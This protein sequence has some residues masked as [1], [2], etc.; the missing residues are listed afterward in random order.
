MTRT[1]PPLN[2]QR[3]KTLLKLLSQSFIRVYPMFQD[4]D[5]TGLIPRSFGRRSQVLA[6]KLM[7]PLRPLQR[8]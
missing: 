7:R 2:S 3:K 8:F 4:R 6:T 1:K 5:I